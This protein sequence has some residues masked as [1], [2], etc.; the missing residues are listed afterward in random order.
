MY[1][2]L[3]WIRFAIARKNDAF[4]AKI[5]NTRLTKLVVGIVALAGRLPTSVTLLKINQKYMD[6]PKFTAGTL[7]RVLSD[8]DLDGDTLPTK[9]SEKM[10]RESNKPKTWYTRGI[11]TRPYPPSSS[12]YSLTQLSFNTSFISLPSL[13]DWTLWVGSHYQCCDKQCHGWRKACPI[14]H[15]CCLV[16]WVCFI[17][18]PKPLRIQPPLSSGKQE[19]ALGVIRSKKCRVK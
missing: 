9:A 6:K 15:R 17:Y 14:L 2:T 8:I 7:E 3:N 19:K 13:R 16:V 18:L 10:S 5:A 12:K 1:C 4:I 11:K